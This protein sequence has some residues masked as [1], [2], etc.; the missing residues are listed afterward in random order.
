V[1]RFVERALA[2]ANRHGLLVNGIVPIAGVHF[3]SPEPP[4]M[5]VCPGGCRGSGV[6]DLDEPPY[7]AGCS[8]CVGDGIV[9]SKCKRN[10]IDCT[11]EGRHA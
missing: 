10:P 1:S 2:M 6:V 8:T 11:C 4:P 3:A 7:Q 5:I 9:C